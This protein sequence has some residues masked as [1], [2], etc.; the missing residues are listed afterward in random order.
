MIKMI[1]Q[2]SKIK[3][4]KPSVYSIIHTFFSTIFSVILTLLV[5][6]LTA[7][8]LGPEEKGKYDLII[9]AITLLSLILS[10]SLPSGIIYIIAS[11]KSGILKLIKIL[12]LFSILQFI[13]T[14]AIFLLEIN[15]QKTFLTNILF[16]KISINYSLIAIIAI[17][18]F[19]NIQTH[20]FKAIL[21]GY[22]RIIKTNQYDLISKIFLPI[23]LL[24][25]IPFINYLEQKTSYISYLWITLFCI[26]ITNLLYLSA[27]REYFRST[28]TYPSNIYKIIRFSAPCYLSNVLQLLNYRID[29]FFVAYFSNSISEVGFYTLA[30]T[31]VQLIW[32]FPNSMKT[33]IFAKVAHESQ[34]RDKVEVTIIAARIVFI[35]SII[36]GILMAVTSPYILPVVYGNDFKPVIL[37]LILLLPGVIIFSLTRIFASYL[38]GIGNT[39]V[40]LFASSFGFI[41]TILM[42]IMLI[43]NYGINGAAIASTVSYL[44]STLITLGSISHQT[45]QTIFE[46]S[47]ISY[48]DIQYILKL[49]KKSN[50]KN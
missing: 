14:Y 46:I 5:S 15:T 36:L 31:L 1:K 34:Q 29:I 6:V 10:F 41:A 2:L 27:L 37:P 25:G 22:Q 21:I 7:R 50:I 8:F 45:N 40:N 23:F 24:L 26:I 39:R 47:I 19:F 20:Y 18:L 49:L 48:S 35:I 17:Y 33:V 43:P 28:L 16:P 9:S 4:I 13:L 11:K 12:S 32:L 44:I 42:D 3:S 38:A 30:A